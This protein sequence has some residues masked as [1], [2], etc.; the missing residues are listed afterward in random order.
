[1]RTQRAVQLVELLTAGCGHGNRDPKVLAPLAFAK[2]NGR[3][4]KCGIKS[5]GNGGDCV[6]IPVHFGAH[7]FYREL[8]GVFN[9]RRLRMGM[10]CGWRIG[11][12]HCDRGEK[13]GG[14]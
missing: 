13:L 9:E 8:A 7:N 14:K 10:I 12:G 5:V 3:G 4:V 11:V 1:M 6:H 2:F